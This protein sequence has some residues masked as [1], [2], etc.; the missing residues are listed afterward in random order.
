[1]KPGGIK[2]E[3]MDPRGQQKGAKGCQNERK[4]HRKGAKGSQK[5]VEGSQK[6]AKERAKRIQKSMFGK[7]REKVAK[8]SVRGTK[9]WSHFWSILH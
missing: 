9:F 1:M 8:R 6:G 3:K 2:S 4:G 7:G 5:G